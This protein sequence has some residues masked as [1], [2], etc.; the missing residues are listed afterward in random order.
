[1]CDFLV[2][3]YM[4]ELCIIVN[5]SGVGLTDDIVGAAMCEHKLLDL[6]ESAWDECSCE[7]YSRNLIPCFDGD[8]DQEIGELAKRKRKAT[9]MM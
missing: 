8:M 1:M 9:V 7:M 2:N 6:N 4:S 3:K 5:K